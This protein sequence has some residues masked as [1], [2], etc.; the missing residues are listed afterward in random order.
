MGETNEFIHEFINQ[1]PSELHTEKTVKTG[2][3][4][5]NDIIKEL[6][7]EEVQNYFHYIGSLTTPPY[8]E[9]V[10]WYV[11]KHIY[12]ASSEQIEKIKETEGENA[13]KIQKLNARKVEN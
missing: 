1:I 13:R 11:S 6:P 3:I 12:E 5:L 7:E 8:T 10:N 2:T 4:K 9:T